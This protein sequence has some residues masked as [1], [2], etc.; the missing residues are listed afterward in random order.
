MAIRLATVADLPAIN[1][2]YNH[3][4]LHS[5]ATYAESLV[6]DE[7]RAAWFAGHGERHPVTVVELEGEIAGW[8]SLSP[9]RHR[10]AYRF[11]AEDSVYL[12]PDRL[13]RGLGS[14]LLGDLLGRAKAM[15]FHT[16]IGGC[17]TADPS[18]AGLHERFGFERVAHFREVGFKFGAWRDVIFLQR[19]L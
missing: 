7:E 17:D 16:I 12:R 14:A 13:R 18:S 11:S 3:Y 1:E 19:M 4:V 9:Y 5:T 6:T 10:E 2:I 8:A 15:G